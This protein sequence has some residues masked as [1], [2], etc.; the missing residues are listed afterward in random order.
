MGKR[1]LFIFPQGL[2]YN[3]DSVRYW[4]DG[5][6]AKDAKYA[7]NSGDMF[8]TEASLKL[9]DFDHVES[10][11]TDVKVDDAAIAR[12]NAEFDYCIFRGSNCIHEKMVWGNVGTFIEK[13]KLPVIGFSIGAQAPRYEQVQLSDETKRVMACMADRA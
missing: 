9:M 4:D 1:V 10:V 2:I 13:V 11:L 5:N 6:P 8:V 7:Y 3:R 12:Y